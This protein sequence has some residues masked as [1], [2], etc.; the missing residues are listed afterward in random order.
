MSTIN[1]SLL[2]HVVVIKWE[3]RVLEEGLICLFFLRLNDCKPLIIQRCDTLTSLIS[4]AILNAEI[5]INNQCA[6][7]GN[8]GLFGNDSAGSFG[9]YYNCCSC[10]SLL[11][12]VLLE[13]ISEKAT[14]HETRKST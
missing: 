4:L 5:G 8:Y 6:S 1:I 9:S 14:T 3:G 10:M 7:N 11:L 13:I 2:I 12:C